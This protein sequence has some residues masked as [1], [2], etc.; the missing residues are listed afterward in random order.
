MAA[1]I[2]I[3]RIKYLDTGTFGEMFVDGKHFCY[4]LEDVCRFINGDISKKVPG[5]TCIDAGTYR[6]IVD[7]SQRFG[8]MMPHIL[9][10]PCFDGVRLHGGNTS[11]DTEGCPLMGR[12]SNFSTEIWDCHGLVD[13]LIPII[14]DG[15]DIEIVD[16]VSAMA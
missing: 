15:I 8:R 13:E 1:K 14:G 4:T 10:V 6:L 2:Q 11:K 3:K 7:Y 9:N 16:G 12:Q 5:E